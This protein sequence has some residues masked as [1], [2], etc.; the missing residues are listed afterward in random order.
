MY[1]KFEE[2]SNRS[3][4]SSLSVSQAAISTPKDGSLENLGGGEF[5]RRNYATP[6]PSKPQRH[7]NKPSEKPQRWSAG[8]VDD[9]ESKLFGKQYNFDKQSEGQYSNT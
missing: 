2:L 3:S 5:L 6:P 1:L 4:H 8:P 7:E 9:W